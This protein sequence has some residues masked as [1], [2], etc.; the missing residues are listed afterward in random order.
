MA[1]AFGSMRL[2]GQCRADRYA[3]MV[4][5]N[6]FNEAKMM[7]FF[8]IVAAN[9][10]FLATQ[11]VAEPP[12][13][14]TNSTVSLSSTTKQE[15]SYLIRSATGVVDGVQSAKNTNAPASEAVCQDECTRLS[16]ACKAFRVDVVNGEI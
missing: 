9:A 11:G 12:H 7:F 6:K 5:C 14:S 1:A 2:L 4:D 13:S 3:Y 16:D 10:G 8:C 15:C